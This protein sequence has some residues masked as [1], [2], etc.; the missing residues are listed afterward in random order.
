MPAAMAGVCRTPSLVV[1]HVCN[2]QKLYQAP[3]KCIPCV[4]VSGKRA[5]ARGTSHQWRQ[6]RAERRVQALDERGIK[7]LASWRTPQTSPEIAQLT[8]GQSVAQP[9]PLASV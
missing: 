4:S 1:R 2:V 6:P 7:Y 8:M 9:L 3:T 5:S